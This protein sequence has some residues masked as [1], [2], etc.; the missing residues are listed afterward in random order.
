MDT[1]DDRGFA[2]VGPIDYGTVFH[3]TRKRQT[4]YNRFWRSL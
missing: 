3:R 1:F 4:S 2:A